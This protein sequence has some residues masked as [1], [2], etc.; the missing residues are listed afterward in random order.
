MFPSLAEQII[1]DVKENLRKL[2]LK[3][4]AEDLEKVLRCQIMD[5]SKKDNRIRQLVRK[6]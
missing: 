5:I 2:D 3:P 6:S 1:R 4:L